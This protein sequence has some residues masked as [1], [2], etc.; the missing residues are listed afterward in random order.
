MKVAWESVP[1][2]G[3][4]S[5]RFLALELDAF[6]AP[7]HAHD[8][9]ELTWIERGHG[10]RLVGDSVE[11]FGPG[12]VTLVAPRVPHAWLTS[13]PQEGRVRAQVLQLRP[14]AELLAL[15]E[16]RADMGRLL[17]EPASA[18]SIGGALAAQTQAAFRAISE[19]EGLLRLGTALAALGR[20]ASSEVEPQQR[21]PL[22][23]HAPRRS[24]P[25]PAQPR[26][27]DALLQW[28]RSH[29][30]AELSA[31]EAAALLHVTPAA[32]SRAFRRL[33]GKPFS[34]YVN[35]LR[36]AEACLLLRG[37]D[38]SISDVARQCGFPTLSN[39]NLQFRRRA[40]M[41]PR[42]YRGSGA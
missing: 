21:R 19:T 16:W 24:D 11:P 2:G 20:L 14:T 9:L 5:L 18:W 6:A 38:R 8:L 31:V 25:D 35:D 23:L 39:F 27:V 40:G 33:V 3:L 41:S 22:A 37:T 17:A 13:G 12:D 29:L 4:Q 34:D 7:F 32:F 36:I 28:I 15:P 30:H 10:L 1:L 26:R 42:D